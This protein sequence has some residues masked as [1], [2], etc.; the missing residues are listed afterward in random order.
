MP[1]CT[2]RERDVAKHSHSRT[3]SETALVTNERC[4]RRLV[5]THGAVGSPFSVRGRTAPGRSR[6]A[7]ENPVLASPNRGALAWRRE[8]LP[9]RHASK[10]V[11]E[12]SMPASVSAVSCSEDREEPVASARLSVRSVRGHCRPRSPVSLP[13]YLHR[14]APV[15]RDR[16]RA[17]AIR[18]ARV[19][20]RSRP[21]FQDSPGEE[22]CRTNGRRG[23]SHGQT[24]TRVCA[25]EEPDLAILTA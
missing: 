9:D 7:L 13:P 22:A 3:N 23:L 12:T 16:S 24:P 2:G 15:V 10:V 4:H 20:V 11:P 17:A 21:A 6:S 19:H 25:P 5:V 1:L 18:P 14:A 8:R